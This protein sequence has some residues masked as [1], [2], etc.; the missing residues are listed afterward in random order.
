MKGGNTGEVPNPG[1]KADLGEDPERFLERSI[2]Y[3]GQMPIA[4]IKGIDD[5]R[6]V[7]VWKRIEKDPDRAAGEPR[8]QIMQLLEEREQ[9]LVQHGEREERTAGETHDRDL[10]PAEVTINGESADDRSASA[11]AKIN[12]MRNEPVVATDG[13]EDDV[14]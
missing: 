7:R 2:S 8:E 10:P 12:S 3:D 9:F 6:V 5:L 14:E 4:R 13:G 11:T 1:L